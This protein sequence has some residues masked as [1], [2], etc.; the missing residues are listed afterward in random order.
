MILT[1]YRIV[2]INYSKEGQWR[3]IDIPLACIYEDGFEELNSIINMFSGKCKD[4]YYAIR[5]ISSFLVKL[6]RADL[7]AFKFAYRTAYEKIEEQHITQNID[8]SYQISLASYEFQLNEIKPLMPK[9]QRDELCGEMYKHDLPYSGEH[10]L[11]LLMEAMIPGIIMLEFKNYTTLKANTLPKSL[12]EAEFR[13]E[14]K[15]MINK[16]PAISFNPAFANEAPV[17]ELSAHSS[18]VHPPP[19]HVPPIY[20]PAIGSFIQN[21]PINKSFTNELPINKP[22]E[23]LNPINFPKP[24]YPEVSYPSLNNIP[25]ERAYE[26]IYPDLNKIPSINNSP[27]PSP[28]VLCFECKK[29]SH[30]EEIEALICGHYK[31]RECIEK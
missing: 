13:F 6:K 23:N 31:H 2:I 15:A 25:E 29:V 18:S 26:G 12:E 17:K 10:Y 24:E 30:I 20:D 11:T 4:F 21:P 1:S 8:F 16:E 19:T 28:F 9:E 22:H 7:P 5:E 14:D 3:S 27:K